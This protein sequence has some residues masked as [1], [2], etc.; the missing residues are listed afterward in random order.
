MVALVALAMFA[1]VVMGNASPGQG[2]G[3]WT[4]AIMAICLVGGI[5]WG[6][7]YR[8]GKGAEWAS[9]GALLAAV[10]VAVFW[11]FGGTPGYVE[12]TAG[13]LSRAEVHDLEQQRRIAN[14]FVQMAYSRKN[15]RP[16]ELPPFPIELDGLPP[17]LRQRFEQQRQ[18]QLAQLQG[19]WLAGMYEHAFGY[20]HGW[21]RNGPLEGGE[22]FQR[23]VV[24]GFLLN[25]EADD[26]GI[27]IS[28]EAVT[29]FIIEVPGEAGRLGKSELREILARMEVS[30]GQLYDALRH[31]LRARQAYT[32]LHP[33]SYTTPEEFWDYYRRLTVSQSLAALPVPVSAFVDKEAEPD[34]S[35]LA[36]LFESHRNA[37]PNQLGPGEPGFRQ[38]QKIRLGYLAI[39]A[40]A[41]KKTIS[42]PTEDE[43]VAFYEAGRKRGDYDIRSVPD[44]GG[45]TLPPPSPGPT[46]PGD[47][48]SPAD[49]KD[50]DANPDAPKP[51]DPESSD[52]ESTDPAPKDD[53]STDPKPDDPPPSDTEKPDPESSDSTE[54]SEDSDKADEATN[55]TESSA[56]DRTPRGTLLSVSD[57][58]AT[59]ADDA[60]KDD[61]ADDPK[62]DG[63]KSDESPKGDETPKDDEPKDDEPKDE[64]GPALPPTGGTQPETGDD[65]KTDNPPADDDDPK[66][67]ATDNPETPE[68][69]KYEPKVKP[70]EEVREE[71][72]EQLVN[73]KTSARIDE[74]VE[75][76]FNHMSGLQLD[77]DRTTLDTPD[78]LT[79]R[80]VNRLMVDY[81]REQGI[82]YITTEL[83]DYRTLRQSGDYAIGTARTDATGQF[84]VDEM[85]DAPEIP[86]NPV[87]ARESFG[88]ARYVAWKLA[89][90]PSHAGLLEPQDVLP[91]ITLADV[92]DDLG[93]SEEDRARLFPRAGS[94]KTIG[95]YFAAHFEKGEIEKGSSIRVG[96]FRLTAAEVSNGK[97]TK[98]QLNEPGIRDQVVEAWRVQQARP[99]AEARARELAKLARDKPGTAMAV[100]FAEKTVTGEE[101]GQ[102]LELPTITPEFSWMTRRSTTSRGLEQRL[103]PPQLTDI[104]GI[105]REG[106]EFME[107]VFRDLDNGE[108]GVVPNAD[109]SLYYIVKVRERTPLDPLDSETHREEF[110]SVIRAEGNP[111]AGGTYTAFGNGETNLIGRNWSANLEKKYDVRFN[112]GVTR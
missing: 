91:S 88:E 80:K 51:T 95:E 20:D 25:K 65:P 44:A 79:I 104:P 110:M 112:F 48:E 19:A 98:L 2:G 17:E 36:T 99:K 101:D 82:E 46:D 111:A 22:E 12:T 11:F 100:V 28:D 84:V 61:P 5:A 67:D 21:S 72:V 76:A 109:R 86:L 16:N 4:L 27:K 81:A 54:P 64:P 1:F 75:A 8:Q 108:I 56:V 97:A 33:R 45:P 9:T 89:D 32:L 47:P 50:D 26:L 30:E 31:E 107:A 58:E 40:E 93:F 66:T 85:F 60:A 90:V 57:D 42:A 23:D 29:D 73:D 49:P 53:E 87:R 24:F 14:Q 96:Q 18:E 15:P 39:E 92:A 10:F 102:T 78:A 68:K 63:P 41:I 55:D 106:E 52:P 94:L 77:F 103:G 70:L 105:D 6:L 59:R 43:I 38:L 34:Q 35:T 7:G 74:I 3:G 71:I 69:E 37:F 83:L 13:K 62:D